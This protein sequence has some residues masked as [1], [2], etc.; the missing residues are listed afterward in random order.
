MKFRSGF[1]ELLRAATHRDI[2]ETLG[3]VLRLFFPT[4]AKIDVLYAFLLI[5][6]LATT[7]EYLACN[8]RVLG[9]DT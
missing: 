9:S 1:P 4:A 5:T 7:L 6:V 2:A 8:L 3:A